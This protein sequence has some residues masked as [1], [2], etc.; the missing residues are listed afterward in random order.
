MTVALPVGPGKHV[1]CTSLQSTGRGPDYHAA[2]DTEHSLVE[3]NTMQSIFRRLHVPIALSRVWPFAAARQAPAAVLWLS[4]G[5]HRAVLPRGRS[6]H[7]EPP[8]W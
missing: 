5:L 4:A 8:C 7:V 1:M 2:R 6:F 3:A